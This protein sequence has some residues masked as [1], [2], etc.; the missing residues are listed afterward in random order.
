VEGRFKFDEITA[1]IGVNAECQANWEELKLDTE[2]ERG[3]QG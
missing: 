1:K 3:V 2:R